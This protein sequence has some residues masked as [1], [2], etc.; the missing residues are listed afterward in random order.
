MTEHVVTD[1]LECAER[2]EPLLGALFECADELSQPFVA[3]GRGSERRI[4]E[5]PLR[6]L[7]DLTR[8]IVRGRQTGRKRG[9]GLSHALEGGLAGGFRDRKS[10]AARLGAWH[11]R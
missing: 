1:V 7:E 4:V 2:L 6:V 3:G 5:P 9:R 8:A 11:R 10:A